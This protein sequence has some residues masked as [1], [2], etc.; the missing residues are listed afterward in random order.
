[1][2]LVLD[3]NV[4]VRALNQK[5]EG[6]DE[7]RKLLDDLVGGRLRAVEPVTVLVEVSG[8]LAR[9]VDEETSRSA[10]DL[11][12]NCD[13]VTWEPVEQGLAAEAARLAREC[14]LKGADAIFAAVAERNEIPLITYDDELRKKAGQRIPVHGTW[15]P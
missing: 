2:T 10:F 4:I 5:E 6:H 14:K 1:M 3:A 7:A 8:A 9:R 12:L 13:S 15:P 11:L